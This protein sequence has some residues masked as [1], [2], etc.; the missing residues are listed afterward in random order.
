MTVEQLSKIVTLK[1]LWWCTLVKWYQPLINQD[2]SL[3]EESS[4]EQLQLVKKL[5][6]WD[7]ITDQEKKTI[8]MKNQFK[9][10]YWWWVEQLNTFQTSHAETQLVWLEL[11]NIYWKPEQFLTILQL[12]TLDLWNIQYLQSLELLLNVNMLKIYQN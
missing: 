1:D 8:Y 6:S 5:E 7:L 12:I 11:I 4:Q 3:S 9:E 2:F 10:Q